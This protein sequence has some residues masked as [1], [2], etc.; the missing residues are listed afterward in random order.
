[1]AR[2]A[3]IVIAAVLVVLFLFTRGSN[4]SGNQDG[5]SSSSTSQVTG[6]LSVVPTIRSITVSPGSVTFHDCTGGN[7]ATNSTPQAM[8]YPNGSCSVGVT[9]VNQSFPITVT[10]TGLPGTVE[11][12]ATSA[13]PSD[14]GTNWSLCSPPGQSQ[15]NCTGGLGLPG[16]DQY[17][18]ENF[19]QA[20]A[21]A[22]LVT[23]NAACDK[24][25]D[26]G[27]GGGCSASPAEF[28]SQT[29][30][31]GLM[32]TGPSTWDDHSTSWTMTVTWTAVGP[33][34]LSGGYTPTPQAP[35]PA[36]LLAAAPPGRKDPAG[37]SRPGN[38]EA[39]CARRGLPAETG[40]LECP[41]DSRIGS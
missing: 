12:N 23:G 16:K 17:T 7:G 15:P 20:V 38:R 27:P 8:G 35:R 3:L 10:Y 29:Q 24:Q 25:F 34:S 11:V 32:L 26:Q 22:T 14:G 37:P 30:H 13:V 1:M 33:Q 9:G 2:S 28:Q 18:V 21:N 31:E 41:V 40:Y 19:G 36:T 5:S 6:H 39:R 4:G